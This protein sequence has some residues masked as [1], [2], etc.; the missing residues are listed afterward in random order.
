MSNKEIKLIIEGTAANE[1]HVDLKVFLDEL[2]AFRSALVRVDKSIH[3]EQAG[4]NFLI[5]DLS[6]S[7]PATITLLPTARNRKRDLTDQVVGKF[8]EVMNSVATGIVPE[9]ADYTLL[10]CLRDITKPVGKALK[11][12]T[13]LVRDTGYD[14]DAEFLKNLAA[15]LGRSET[16][17]GSIEG[18]LEQIDLHSQKPH[19]TIFPL[20]GPTRVKCVFPERLHDDAINSLEKRVLVTGELK[21]RPK[22]HFPHEIAVDDL[23]VHPIDSE[24]PSFDALLGIAPMTEDA[25]PSEEIIG[26]IR[27]AWD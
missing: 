1:G 15:A 5:S 20:V 2:A 12:A 14:I 17:L 22:A 6:H 21:Y 4:T 7:S 16:C 23:I 18:T 8:T 25:R 19:F 24:L 26:E 10:E 11:S 3:N 13:V 9:D 27:D